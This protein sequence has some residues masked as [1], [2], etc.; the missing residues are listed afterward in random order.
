MLS[1]CPVELTS[2]P[3]LQRKIQVV[4]IDVEGLLR[5]SLCALI[6][7]EPELELTA[8]LP[9]ASTLQTASI[10]TDPDVLVIDLAAP[11]TGGLEAVSAAR[12]RWPQLPV[13]NLTFSHDDRL[14]ETALRSGV[15][16]YILKTD[17]RTEFLAAIHSAIAGKRYVSSS[18]FET[19]VDGFV[20]HQGRVIETDGLSDRER[21]VMKL[22]AQGL[23]TREIATQLSVN[24]KTVEKHRGNL[25]RK[26]GLRS[27]ASVAAYAIANGYVRI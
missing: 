20:S 19:V 22:I 1:L 18:I 13:V 5:D 27:A 26:L 12:S 14:I 7:M 6:N 23:R 15:L 24:Y 16:G 17:S 4:L 21:E 9:T 11:D 8:V 10:V 25:M 2:G 3:M